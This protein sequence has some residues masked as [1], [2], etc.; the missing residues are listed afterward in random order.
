MR[1]LYDTTRKLAVKH[2]KLERSVGEKEGNIITVE[3]I[4]RTYWG[5]L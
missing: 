5:S 4:D 3:Q 1:Q 2:G